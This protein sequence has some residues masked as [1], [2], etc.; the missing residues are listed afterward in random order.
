LKLLGVFGF[1]LL[2]SLGP[3]SGARSIFIGR[4]RESQQEPHRYHEQ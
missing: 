1:K 2:M 4:R 3:F